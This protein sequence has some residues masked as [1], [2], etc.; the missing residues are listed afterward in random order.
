MSGPNN[1]YG[2]P[3]GNHLATIITTQSLVT[4]D[5]TPTV[6]FNYPLDAGS[7]RGFNVSARCFDDAGAV[8]GYYERRALFKRT[9]SGTSAQV[10]STIVIGTDLETDGGLDVTLALSTNTVQISV[11]G[12]AST[13]LRWRLVVEAN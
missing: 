10:G 4:A 12:K 13:T 5:A 2:D 8:A 7:A 1:N 11:T 6:A 3:Y 9:S